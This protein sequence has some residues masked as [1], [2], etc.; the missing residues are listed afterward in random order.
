MKKLMMTTVAA[1]GFAALAQAGVLNS[2][3]FE[4]Y[5]ENDFAVGRD[6]QGTGDN[7]RYWLGGTEGGDFT[8][9]VLKKYGEDPVPANVPDAFTNAANTTF[10]SVDTGNDVL[11]R[12]AATN[13]TDT[14]DLSDGPVFFDADVKFTASE[15]DVVAS[16]GDKLLVWLKGDD[17]TTNLIVTAGLYNG[18]SGAYD[19]TPFIIDGDYSADTWYRLTVKATRV[20]SGD[21]ENY[22]TAFNVYIDGK[23]VTSGDT[24]EFYSL[25]GQLD[26]KSTTLEAAGFQGTGALDNVVWTTTDPFPAEA[27]YTLAV[28]IEDE[29][30]DLTAIT[31]NGTEYLINGSSLEIPFLASTKTLEVEASDIFEGMMIQEWNGVSTTITVADEL[32]D[33]RIAL[34]LTVVEDA[35]IDVE[36]ATVVYSINADTIK[37]GDAAPTVTSVT[38]NE[39]VLTLGT[40]YTVTSVGTVEAVGEYKL[41]IDG[42]GAYKGQIQKT[43]TVQAAGP[44]VPAEAETVPG[45]PVQVKATDSEAAVEAVTVQGVNGTVYEASQKYYTKAAVETG[46][47]GVFE[48]TVALNE[49][50]LKTDVN[51]AVEAAL[52]AVDTGATSVA[53][54]AGFYYKVESG[55]AL[56]IATTATGTPD[57]SEIEVKG[58]T[59]AAGFFKVSVGTTEFAK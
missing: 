19:K 5:G 21:G 31:V 45:T 28:T 33:G 47:E 13:P 4:E 38:V 17:T 59:K 35:R 46:T 52:A 27:T 40:D 55:S 7:A 20:L 41:I 14:L 37:V 30:G 36:N 34:T 16:T 11:L 1:L 39:A 18:T 12:R 6:D 22:T 9:T 3:G 56:P 49:T 25:L 50:E 10:L 53:L 24:K 26:T 32:E 58:L 2:T 8:Q 42:K 23:L 44:D 48:V 54:P 29:N 51:K 57:G 43:F 15:T